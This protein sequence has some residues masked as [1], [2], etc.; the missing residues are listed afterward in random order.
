M[1][2]QWGEHWSPEA[3]ARKYT[4]KWSSTTEWPWNEVFLLAEQSED[5]WEGRSD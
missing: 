4:K 3:S 1:L 2:E 5:E